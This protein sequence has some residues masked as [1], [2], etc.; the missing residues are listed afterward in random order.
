MRARA[1][2]GAMWEHMHRVHD[3]SYVEHRP[4]TRIF[5]VT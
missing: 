2:E 3:Q 5:G 4:W 1:E